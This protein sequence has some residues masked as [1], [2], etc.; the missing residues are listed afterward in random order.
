MIPGVT[1]VAI[2]ERSRRIRLIGL[3]STSKGHRMSQVTLTRRRTGWDVALGILLMLAGVVVLAHSVIATAVSVLFIGWML[4][5]S[6]VVAFIASFFHR[7]G[8]SFWL[9]ALSG[10]LMF[11]LGLFM[12]RNPSVAALSLTLMAGSIFLVSGIVRLIVA[13]SDKENRVV[14]I[15]GGAVSTILGL[16]VLFNIFEATLVLLG[17]IVGIQALVEG[18]S[19]LIVGRMHAR[20]S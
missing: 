14:L 16:I 1:D 2:M 20:A 17:V 9:I 15:I 19:L 18:V 13:A 8:G 11:V 7:E 4:L 6:G 3:G 5:L 10:A 12:V